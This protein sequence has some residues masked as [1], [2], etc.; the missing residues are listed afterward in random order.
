[1]TP[2]FAL[3]G[4][5][6][7]LVLRQPAEA[8][9]ALLFFVLG[10]AIF[11]LGVGPDPVLLAR[12]AP[13]L[14]WAMALFASLLSL[15]RLFHADHED[16]T[17]DQLALA[18]LPLW[19]VGLAKALAHWATHGVPLLLVA[20]LLAVAFGMPAAGLPALLAG[21][22]LGGLSMSLIGAV[23]SA[24]TLGARRSGAILPLLV[25]PLYIPVLVFGVSAVEAALIGT[26]VRPHLM[27]LAGL[28]LAALVLAP[29]AIAASLRQAL[30]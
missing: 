30:D 25:L 5:D 26:A 27:L 15:D 1:V 22:V 23:G 19:A 2:F 28:M 12:I 9:L 29:W 21:L 11:P 20:P 17:L 10:G 14:I 3:A 18:S 13:G 8:V 16:G 4:R 24:L 7:R 6:I